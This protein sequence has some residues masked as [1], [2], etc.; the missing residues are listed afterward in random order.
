MSIPITLAEKVDVTKFGDGQVDLKF[1]N[2]FL[3]LCGTTIS[4]TLP[5]C[6]NSR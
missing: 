3:G 6:Y 1:G 5:D 4:N 2:H